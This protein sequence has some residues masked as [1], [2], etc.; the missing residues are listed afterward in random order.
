MRIIVAGGGV[1]GTVSAIA[2]RRLGAE[3]VVFEA[4]P[5]PG[6][7]VGSFLSLASNGLRG[8]AAIGCLDRVRDRGFPVARQR[9][10]S[11]SGRLLGDVARGRRA[12]DPLHSVTLMRAHLVEELRRAALDA[13]VRIV[14]GE[15]LVDAAQRPAGALARF[16]S[17]RTEDAD[18]LV[19]ADGIWSATRHSLD[20]RAPRPVYAGLYSV[21][22]V[23]RGV[24]A[25]EDVFNMVFGRNG[26]FIYL[27]APG[28]E[29][30]WQAQAASRS[31]PHLD[32]VDDAQWLRRLAEVHRAE[33]VPA[34]IIAASVALHRPTIHHVLGP[35]PVGHD[36]HTVLVGDAVHP[37]GA[38]QGASMAIE[39]G[40]ALAAALGAGA[41]VPRAL[42]EY[43]RLRRPRVAK[44]LKAA[45]DNRDIKRAGALRRGVESLVMPL[46]LRHFY[47]RATGWLYD[48]RPEAPVDVSTL[49]PR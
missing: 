38:G 46:V 26:A 27:R 7:D 2:L 3:V 36:G 41:S 8:L 16:A 22:G 35:V 42:L 33:A 9:M 25:D 1:A 31:E 37:V 47:E 11:G 34:G 30:W 5:D 17:G 18:L 23:S 20:P 15:R 4:Y 32:G 48:Y 6:G 44:L 12:D 40:V 14:S 21:A 19:G 29:V 39:D 24:E 49:A 13:G 28:G 45:G 10:W 43:D